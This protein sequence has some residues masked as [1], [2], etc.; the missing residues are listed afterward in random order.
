MKSC[1]CQPK[2]RAELI[3]GMFSQLNTSSRSTNALT[4]VP[5]IFRMMF[6]HVPLAATHPHL[7][8][9]FS[10]MHV[11]FYRQEVTSSQ[12]SFLSLPLAAPVIHS[13]SCCSQTYCGSALMLASVFIA[14]DLLGKASCSFETRVE[15]KGDRDLPVFTQWKT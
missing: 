1:P 12:L 6:Q 15:L 8:S 9:F 2:C 10:C 5:R 4:N 3:L 11:Q 13:K 7:I 14:A